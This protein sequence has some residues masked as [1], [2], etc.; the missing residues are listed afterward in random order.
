MTEHRP[1]LGALAAI[2]AFSI[3]TVACATDTPERAIDAGDPYT[4]K[5]ETKIVGD[6]VR[7]LREACPPAAPI[8]EVAHTACARGLAASAVLR[9]FA[10][11]PFLWGREVDGQGDVLARAVTVRL[12]PLVF[13][14][15]Y[16]SLFTFS[17]DYSVE[18]EGV[19]TI[20]RVPTTFRNDLSAA[21]YPY[22]FWSIDAEWQSYELAR[23]LLF[24]IE[25]GR[26]VGALRSADEDTSRPRRPRAWDGTY[27]PSPLGYAL[28]FS[29]QNRSVAALDATQRALARELAPYGCTLCHAPPNLAR[30]SPLDLLLYPNEMLHARRTIVRSIERG[31]MPPGPALPEDARER[32]LS[33]ARAFDAAADQALADEGERVSPP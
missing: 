25:G 17:G 30:Q 24:V 9:D 4:Q 29:A 23:E 2:V 13:R 3:T 28:L 27:G 20:L 7:S 6:L 1:R 18:R 11:E 12:A 33:A 15:L 32:L 21:S 26:I 19:R 31:A 16:L 8:D 22:P 14:K 5:L 10:A